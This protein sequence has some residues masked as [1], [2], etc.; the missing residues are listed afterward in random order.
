M[1]TQGT[2]LTSATEATG[3]AMAVGLCVAD[4]PVVAIG[5]GSAVTAP[6]VEGVDGALLGLV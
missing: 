2:S 5:W 6:A 1:M 3:V 4:A